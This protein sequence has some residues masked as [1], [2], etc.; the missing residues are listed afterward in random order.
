MVDAVAVSPAFEFWMSTRSRIA[1]VRALLPSRYVAH[2]GKVMRDALVAIDAGL[3]TRKKETLMSI[4]RAGTLTRDI[5]RLRAVAVA[6]F[7]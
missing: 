4:H 6:A 5:H 7:K 2:V 1:C 3:F